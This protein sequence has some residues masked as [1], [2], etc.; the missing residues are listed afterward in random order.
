[1]LQNTK[2]K[3]TVNKNRICKVQLTTSNMYES[4]IKADEIE[5]TLSA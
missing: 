5:I 1:M 3:R 2:I 4:R